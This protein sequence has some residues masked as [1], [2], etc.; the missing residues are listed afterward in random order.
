MSQ[1]VKH[2]TDTCKLLKNKISVNNEKL[3]AP[4][5]FKKYS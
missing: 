5:F 1:I 4:R 3:Q 2:E